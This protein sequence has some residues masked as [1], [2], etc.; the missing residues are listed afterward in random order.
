MR[1]NTRERITT[2]DLC[3]RYNEGHRD[4]SNI[5]LKNKDLKDKD[6]TGANFS[7]AILTGTNFMSSGT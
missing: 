4:F 7:G 5:I 3:R 1:R 2:Q 6:L